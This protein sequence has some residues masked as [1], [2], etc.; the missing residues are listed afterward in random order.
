MLLI[1]ADELGDERQVGRRGVQGLVRAGEDLRELGILDDPEPLRLHLV[2][3]EQ[4]SEL[5]ARLDR[6][7][8]ARSAR[9]RPSSSA[10]VRDVHASSL[11]R[12]SRHAP[13]RA[14]RCDLVELGAEIVARARVARAPSGSRSS[15]G[16][17]VRGPS[18]R[19]PSSRGSRAGRARRRAGRRTR[20]AQL[21]PFASR[22]RRI[23]S[24]ESISRSSSSGR[25]RERVGAS[26][27]ARRCTRTPRLVE[28]AAVGFAEPGRE[29]PRLLE[30]RV[31]VGHARSQRVPG[32]PELA[33]RRSWPRRTP[34][35]MR[36]MQLLGRATDRDLRR[37]R[38]GRAR[39]AGPRDLVSSI[40]CA[41]E[42]G[43]ELVRAPRSCGGA[44][45]RARAAASSC[46]LPGHRSVSAALAAAQRRPIAGQRA[47]LEQLPARVDLEL[48]EVGGDAV[49]R[50]LEARQ[51]AVGSFAAH[52]NRRTGL[53][54]GLELEPG[55][56]RAT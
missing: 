8:L 43:P 6:S 47:H 42:Q 16:L 36:A 27:A 12:A 28:V 55:T 37:C 33:P 38:G 15:R 46:A 14:R 39:R 23:A 18:L 34:S 22:S 20:A 13:E 56:G 4:G 32:L 53:G 35:D 48:D 9:R 51:L 31:R 17:L 5:V 25:S 45:R 21:R 3:L 40:D 2:G 11:L 49:A 41:V 10:S 52:V 29:R 26:A 44:S 24:S 19:R 30:G 50:L 7:R 54:R 1:A